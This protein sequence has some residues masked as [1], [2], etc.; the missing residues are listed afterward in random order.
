MAYL[1]NKPAEC[2]EAPQPAG[3]GDGVMFGRVAV[4]GFAAWL[5]LAPGASSAEPGIIAS[6]SRPA[7]VAAAAIP[8][9]SGND[10]QMA[11][12]EPSVPP[13]P[14]A[15]Q[16]FGRD[17][18]PLRTG[19]ILEKWRGVQGDISAENEVLARCRAGS[20]HCPGVARQF[21][22]IVDGAAGRSGRA[23]IRLINRGINLAIRPMSDLE[24]WGVDDR[25]SAP[26]DTLTTGLGDCEDYAIAK[27]VALIAAG[28]DPADVRLV[29]ARDLAT[30]EDHAVTAV[31]DDGDW[32]ILDNR[33]RALIEDTGVHNVAPLFVI[34]P[35]GVKIYWG[36]AEPGAERVSALSSGKPAGR[37][38]RG[39][40][41]DSAS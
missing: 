33:N 31:R 20:E 13:G 34:D 3:Q 25:W 26:L 12:L 41:F 35:E 4:A 23:R 2:A 10:K 9:S 29:I 6:A 36:P 21:L 32:L 11:K 17:A 7:A 19:E 16:P 38:R 5:V 22:A 40:Y 15:A 30:G 37:A 1:N 24:Q 14:S 27:Y 8:T 28:L 18:V 39:A